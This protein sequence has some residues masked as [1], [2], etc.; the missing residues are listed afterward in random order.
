MIKRY[1]L[2]LAIIAV[3]I[4]F[5]NLAVYLSFP[6]VAS[7]PP[8]YF[9]I[10]FA[11]LAAPICL[12]PASLVLARRSPI[13]IWCYAFIMVSAVWLLAQPLPSETAWQALRT[14]MLSCFVLLIL[15]CLFF[16]E[17]AQRWARRAIL[18]AV[19]LAV[20]IN[21]YELFN[22]LTFSIVKG[23]S[24]GLY[25]NPNQCGAALVLGMI[26]SIGLLRQRYRLFFVFLIGLGV[27]LTVS[28]GAIVSWCVVL[29]SMIV[30]GQ[31]SL[32]RS[33]VFAVA[34][35]ASTAALV[36]FQWD[37]L[38]DQLTNIGVLNK[39]VSK[40]IESFANPQDFA[41]DDSAGQR[42]EVLNG[43]WEMFAD[44]P[45]LGYGVAASR[46][47]GYEVSS[48]N[49]YL[50]LMVDHGV[51]GFFILPLIVL[52][53][54][55]RARG[56]A[57]QMASSFAAFILCWGFF[58]HNVLE[59]YYILLNFSLLGSMTLLGNLDQARESLR[60]ATSASAARLPKWVK[61]VDSL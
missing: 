28:R 41:A 23:R 14:R 22:P 9:I 7:V 55:W 45:I 53:T 37:G 56:K 13:I 32:R 58:S 49:Q 21:I 57:K 31:V 60:F 59:E 18:C 1:R 38:Q 39:D 48:H 42:K 8:L 40:R 17:D 19:I 15:H 36:A 11:A 20:A 30:N 5:T 6:E 43:A 54:I 44:R 51:L 34:L 35:L 33:L 29:L 3:L 16:D 52:A 4:F 46:D 27:V 26:M 61:T 24:A 47:W 10:G 12:S 2:V 25:Y 50:S